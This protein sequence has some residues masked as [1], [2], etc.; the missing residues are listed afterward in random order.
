MY[1]YRIS[2]RVLIS[3]C[4]VDVLQKAHPCFE[5]GFFALNTNHIGYYLHVVSTQVRN[6]PILEIYFE[7]I[8][9]LFL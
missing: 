9:P 8:A 7:A 3:L 6:Q 5:P 4:L 2:K 1:L